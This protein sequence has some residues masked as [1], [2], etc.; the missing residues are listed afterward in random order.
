MD[1]RS[2]SVSESNG[3]AW[4]MVYVPGAD[5]ME[6]KDVPHGAVASVTYYSKS[7]GKFRR[8]HVYTPPGYE[9]SS[10]EI[11]DLLPAARRGRLR[12]FVDL[13]GPRG[14]HPRQPD[15]GQESQA[16]GDRDAGRAHRALPS[17]GC[18]APGSR[19]QR[20]L[21]QG[22]HQR[23][24]ALRRD[25]LSRAARPAASRHRGALDGRRADAQDRRSAPR[26][27]RLRR[28]VQFRASSGSFRSTASGGFAGGRVLPGNSSMPAESG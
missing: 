11:S 26:R 10:Q 14:L 20:R 17:A 21:R 15:R 27:V 28:R 18:Q 23:H 19:F 8:M 24:H 25:A 12:R 9:T 5:F 13:G 6:T 4:S 1:P 3:N 22:F 7:L 2:A 16:D